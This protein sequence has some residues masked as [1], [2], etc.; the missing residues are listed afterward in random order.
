MNKKNDIENGIDKIKLFYENNYNF[1]RAIGFIMLIFGCSISIRFTINFFES[2]SFSKEGKAISKQMAIFAEFGMYTSWAVGFGIRHITRFRKFSNLCIATSLILTILSIMASG[3]ALYMEKTNKEENSYKDSKQY[4]L[5]REE[6]NRK[7]E[8]YN[9]SISDYK[10]SKKYYEKLLDNKDKNLKDIENNYK[11]DDYFKKIKAF[12]KKFQFTNG[13]IPLKKETE[14]KIVEAQ[15]KY[16]SDL[17]N[18]K[19]DMDNKI[20]SKN[21]L[22]IK[23]SDS[24]PIKNEIVKKNSSGYGQFYYSIVGEKGYLI[25][26]YTYLLLAIMI[27]VLINIL[28]YWV[29]VVI[30]IQYNVKPK[31]R[32]K[33]DDIVSS[34]FNNEIP[35]KKVDLSKKNK[36][37]RDLKTL[38]KDVNINLGEINKKD[39][40]I[41]LDV[42]YDNKKVGEKILGLHRIT[43]NTGLSKEICRNIFIWLKTNKIIKVIKQDNST[44]SYS[45]LCKERKDIVINE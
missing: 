12:E 31:I 29:F 44:F 18:A 1:V 8:E 21:E 24:K 40:E 20:I 28:I 43:K 3:G 41:Y 34:Q 22:E 14:K 17:E 38:K 25:E 6:Y 33:V 9:N 35:E 19:N 42:I 2:T 5:K 37:G 32:N 15:K 4:E 16:I 30:K 39:L 26:S 36:I 10:T 45:I 13:S 23:A 11:D 7:I 27:Q